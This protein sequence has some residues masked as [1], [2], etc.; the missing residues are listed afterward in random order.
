MSVIGIVVSSKAFIFR[1]PNRWKSDVVRS[2]ECENTVLTKF[3]MTSSAA[4]P[5][6]GQA[7]VR[8][9]SYRINSKTASIQTSYPFN[10]SSVGGHFHC[11]PPR[12]GGHWCDFPLFVMQCCSSRFSCF[13]SSYPSS[14]RPHIQSGLNLH[15]EQTFVN[16]SEPLTFS[17]QIP[18]HRLLFQRQHNLCHSRINCSAAI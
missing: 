6:H 10:T 12:Q 5:C 13:N 16:S 7:T 9:F 17:N 1:R 4:W 15:F 3:V 8:H 11:R 18:G 14:K 2:D